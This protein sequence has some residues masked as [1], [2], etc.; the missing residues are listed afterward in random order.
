MFRIFNKVLMVFFCLIFIFS[1]SE[2]IKKTTENAPVT[3]EKKTAEPA[4]SIKMDFKILE[5]KSGL[6]I[7]LYNYEQLDLL[8]LK[9]K[10]QSLTYVIN[11]WASWCKPCVNELPYFFE[12]EKKWK[13][14]KVK[15]IYVSLDF[16]D[17]LD[18]TLI[19][20]LD[21]KKYSADFCVLDQKGMDKWIDKIDKNWSGSI[22][23]TLII[24][25]KE[26]KFYEEQFESVDDLEKK[27]KPFLP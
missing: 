14:K 26:R 19:K 25:S 1:C 6:K 24:N 3:T 16:V 7:P 9:P 11:F 18:K 21:E 20:F 4:D 23:A 10:D 12:L 27:L 2:N 8:L 13:D 15:F 5:T 17:K 22:P